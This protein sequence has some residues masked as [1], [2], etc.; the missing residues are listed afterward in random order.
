VQ[1]SLEG[2]EGNKG[3]KGNKQTKTCLQFYLGS[4]SPWKKAELVLASAEV[5][6]V[7]TKCTSVALKAHTL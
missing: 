7:K 4:A 2:R 6:A 1:K 5:K 3:R